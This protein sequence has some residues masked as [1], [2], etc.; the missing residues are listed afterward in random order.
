MKKIWLLF[1]QGVDRLNRFGVA[2]AELS[3]VLLLLLVFHEVVAR[4]LL[5]KP[6][7]Y[8]VELSEYLLLFGAFIAAGWVMRE[9]KHVR[10]QSFLNLLPPR[11]RQIVS[12]LMSVVVLCFCSI[13]VWQ[14]TKA[15]LM[16]FRGGYHSS[17]LLNVPMWIPYSIIPLGSL[18]LTLQ[19]VVL[20]INR[21]TVPDNRSRS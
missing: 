13:L 12:C 11:I 4:Y 9:D 17:S 10:M 1:A 7:T 18:L 21:I 8:S 14:G 5:D 20:L 16:A 19:V 6:T 15:A 3:L 2:A